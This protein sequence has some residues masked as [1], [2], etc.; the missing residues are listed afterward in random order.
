M[1][2]TAW[3]EPWSDYPQYF[4]IV[5]IALKRKPAT[6]MW[7]NDVE[8]AYQTGFESARLYY[9][10]S[11]DTTVMLIVKLVDYVIASWHKPI[12]ISMGPAFPYTTTNAGDTHF[13]GF[14]FRKICVA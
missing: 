1:F 9:A 2:Q 11:G 12:N 14:T 5:L 8:N 10:Y 7:M 4:F 3:A 13:Y 6:D